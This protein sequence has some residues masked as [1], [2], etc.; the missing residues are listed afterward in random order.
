MSRG[1][2]DTTRKMI[3]YVYRT[4]T[5]YGSV[6]QTV[7][8]FNFIFHIVVLQPHHCRNNNGLGCSHF[9]RLYF[10]NNYCYLFLRLLRCFSSPGLLSFRN[11]TASQYRVAPFGNLRIN[12]CLALTRSLSQLA[13]SFI[14]S[15]SQGIRHTPLVTF[16]NNHVGLF[17]SYFIYLPLRQRT[18]IVE[19]IGV[20]PMTPCV[21]GRCSGQL[22]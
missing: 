11:D 3:S 17:N 10:G 1:T 19:N 9:D 5:F 4:V 12:S 18:F 2:Q 14:A 8:Y 15:E 13:T 21:Q 22:S 16:F 20:E 7:F 6:F